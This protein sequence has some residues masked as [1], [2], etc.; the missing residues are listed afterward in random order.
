MGDAGQLAAEAYAAMAC[1][2]GASSAIAVNFVRLWGPKDAIIGM[3]AA[4]RPLAIKMLPIE[5][6][7]QRAREV[8]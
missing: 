8:F 1:S 7:L 4:S 3:S 5:I 6:R 2:G